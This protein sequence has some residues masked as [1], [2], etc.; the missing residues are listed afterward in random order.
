MGRLSKIVDN[1]VFA[2]SPERG[3]ARRQARHRL[4]LSEKRHDV[5]ITRLERRRQQFASGGFSSAEASRDA[6]SWLKSRLS[7]MSA[8]EMDREEMCLRADSAYKNFELGTAHVEGRVVRVAGC[9]MTVD[10]DLDNEDL[11][12]S[13]QEAEDKYQ[14]PAP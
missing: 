1:V 6:D 5:A 12:I 13:E 4:A 11:G 10:P 8:L 3:L 2:I 9:G 7:P 14:P